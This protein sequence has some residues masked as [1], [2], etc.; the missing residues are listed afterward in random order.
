MFSDYDGPTGP[1]VATSEGI[2]HI[3]DPYAIAALA[4]SAML[5]SLGA[6]DEAA[7]YQRRWEEGRRAHTEATRH[8]GERRF[9]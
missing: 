1:Y 8:A 7:E 6:S 9:P 4:H 2:K 5:T 3:A